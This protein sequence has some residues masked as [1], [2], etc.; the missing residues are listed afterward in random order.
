MNDEQRSRR[1]ELV[2]WAIRLTMNTA[3]A[4]SWYERQLLAK[5]VQGGLTIDQV[6][7]ILANAESTQAHK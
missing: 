1:R 7:A 6:L 3:L 2:G 4:P 5:F